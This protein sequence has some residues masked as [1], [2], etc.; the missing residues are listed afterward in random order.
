M[1]RPRRS[2]NARHKRELELT[3]AWTRF[4][5]IK[6]EQV[7][8]EIAAKTMLDRLE[9]CGG[10]QERE[11]LQRAAT[12]LKTPGRDKAAG[13]TRSAAAQPLPLGFLRS[14]QSTDLQTKALLLHLAQTWIE[15]GRISGASSNRVERIASLQLIG[16]QG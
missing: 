8:A 5:D 6:P 12:K 2:H 10:Q 3:R 16:F 11:M 7:F 15:L 1:P 13:L 14:Q 4:S 9:R